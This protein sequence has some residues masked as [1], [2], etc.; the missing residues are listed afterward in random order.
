MFKSLWVAA[1]LKK[2]F[3]KAR[4]RDSVSG[5]SK[6]HRNPTRFKGDTRPVLLDLL[7]WKDRKGDG[8]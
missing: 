8:L 5:P 2:L 3:A 4:V 6:K 1:C 7:G